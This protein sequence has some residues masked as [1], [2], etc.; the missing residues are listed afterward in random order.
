M[1]SFNFV[2]PESPLD[3]VRVLFKEF[4]SHTE[5]YRAQGQD[6]SRSSDYV[7]IGY[8]RLQH[9]VCRRKPWWAPVQS[10]IRITWVFSR[11]MV[12]ISKLINDISSRALRGGDMRSPRRGRQHASKMRYCLVNMSG[13][14]AK[15]KCACM[16]DWILDLYYLPRPRP[17][18][19]TNGILKPYLTPANALSVLFDGKL[20]NSSC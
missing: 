11:R 16:Y 20:E 9:M 4:H 19:R 1:Q 12:L 18:A 10:K 6:T 8:N 13:K 5:K 14:Y 15:K 7:F 3:K 17:W 2:S